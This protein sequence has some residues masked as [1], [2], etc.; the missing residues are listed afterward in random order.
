MRRYRR[1]TENEAGMDITPLV[2]MVF[3]LLVFFIVTAGFV[4]EKVLDV[5]RPS[6]TNTVDV[7]GERITVSLGEEGRISVDGEGK[8]L[9]SAGLAVEE[10][11]LDNPGASVVVAAHRNSRT[12]ELVRLLDILKSAGAKDIG[13]SAQPTEE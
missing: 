4:S 9:R 3:I 6:A 1:R 2:D 5:E 11:L 10:F 12:E 13:L 7:R 8:T